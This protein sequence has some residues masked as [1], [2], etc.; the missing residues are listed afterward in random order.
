M[1]KEENRLTPEE[2]LLTTLARRK[3]TDDIQ[4]INKLLNLT[5]NYKLL[6]KLAN[7]H[8]VAPIIGYHL[9]NNEHSNKVDKSFKREMI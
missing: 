1:D 5:L 2:E 9:S 3:L 8:Q 7:K 4:K 6:S